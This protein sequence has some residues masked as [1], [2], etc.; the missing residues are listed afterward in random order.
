MASVPVLTPEGFRA[1]AP[2]LPTW[3][4]RAFP[5]GPTWRVLSDAP[6]DTG[7]YLELWGVPMRGRETGVGGGG[8]QV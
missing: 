1:A 5:E 4:S 8:Q 6:D 3:W 2:L 7:V